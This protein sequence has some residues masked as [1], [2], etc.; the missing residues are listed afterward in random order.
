MDEGR[1]KGDEQSA[2]SADNSAAPAAEKK[3]QYSLYKGSI[4]FWWFC[5]IQSGSNGGFWCF[6]D[7]GCGN[8]P[9]W[10]WILGKSTHKTA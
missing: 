10:A 2:P 6:A 1:G 9:R 4:K 8:N 7:V 5:R 3:T